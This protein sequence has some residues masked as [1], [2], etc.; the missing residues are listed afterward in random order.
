[1][2]RDMKLVRAIMEY[3]EEHGRGLPIHFPE[4]DGYDDIATEY[5]VK[6][7]NQGKLLDVSESGHP[8]GLTW[9]GHNFLLELRNK[10][11]ISSRRAAG[12]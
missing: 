11:A 4:I 6:I 10:E 7:C 1:M 2:E 12:S 5:H 3:V 9:S 8:T